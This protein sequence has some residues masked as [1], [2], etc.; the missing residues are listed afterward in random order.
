MRQRRAAGTRQSVATASPTKASQRATVPSNDF[1]ADT[2]AIIA[3][4]EL[5]ARVLR[6][7]Q[8]IRDGRKR[9]ALAGF[10]RSE[11]HVQMRVRPECDAP[12]G[13]RAVA[14]EVER[15]EAHR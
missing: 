14:V 12:P 7:E 9:A 8:Q 3:V 15:E 10:V 1:R 2:Q 4:E 5:V 11:H 6:A 13:E